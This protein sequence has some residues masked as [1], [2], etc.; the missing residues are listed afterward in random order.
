[1]PKLIQPAY[2]FYRY[3]FLSRL[4]THKLRALSDYYSDD[5]KGLVDLAF[6]FEYKQ[7]HSR[8]TITPSQ[9]KEEIYELCKLLH[10]ITP[11]VMVEIGS[12]GCGTLFLFARVAS[13]E[14]IISV[15]LPSGPF[16]GGYPAWKIPL[17][18]SLAKNRNCIHLVRADSHDLGTLEGV[19]KILSDGKID[20][21]FIDGDHTYQGVKKDFEMY[22][23]LVKSNGIIAFHDIVEH[24]PETGCEVARFWTEV[25]DSYK[26]VEIVKDWSQKWAGIGVIYM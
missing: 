13:P 19:K 14:I 23:Q 21:L 20:F 3:I 15:D 9:I 26:H 7:L 5:V 16:G 25:K 18:K 17:C 11:K 6:S 24:P 12:A 4:A 10:E 8:I 1:M 2:D 22:S